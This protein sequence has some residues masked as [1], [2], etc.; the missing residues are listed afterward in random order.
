VTIEL[1]PF[2]T[3]QLSFVINMKLTSDCQNQD[4]V[5]R[6]E[7]ITYPVCCTIQSW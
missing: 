1:H 6:I 3:S 5:N 4:K 2:V 7:L